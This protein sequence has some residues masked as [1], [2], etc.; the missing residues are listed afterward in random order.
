MALFRQLAIL[1]GAIL[2]TAE[3]DHAPGPG[4]A[5]APRTGA[6]LVALVRQDLRWEVVD[7]GARTPS[8][9]SSP[10]SGGT[11]VVTGTIGQTLG[12]F[13]GAVTRGCARAAQ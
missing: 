7:G 11:P 10:G 4:N 13:F 5:A 2:L 6:S 1:M 8:P 12:R 3:T 9:G